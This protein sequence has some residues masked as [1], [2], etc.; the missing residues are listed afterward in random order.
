MK[1]ILINYIYSSVNM[2]KLKYKILE[3]DNDLE[4]LLEKKYYISPNF[5]GSST[6]LVFM[7]TSYDRLS[8]I[9]ER[10][11]LFYNIQQVNINEVNIIKIYLDLGYDIYNGTIF[12]GTFLIQPNRK[13][14]IITDCLLLNGKTMDQID[15]STKLNKIKQ[16]IED[17]Y[18]EN[19]DN[20]I[21]ITTNKLTELKDAEKLINVDIVKVNKTIPIRGIIFQPEFTGT[22][23]IFLFNNEM[24]NKQQIND[25]INC[26][27]FIK[28]NKPINAI[29]HMRRTT[30]YDVYNLYLDN[31][32]KYKKIDIAYIPT[33]ECSLLCR[34]ITEKENVI[35]NCEYINN[36]NL[37]KPIE[38]T[39]KQITKFKELNFEEEEIK[40]I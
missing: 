38:K 28:S 4:T 25:K 21:E 1:H 31:D 36:K 3:F 32:N 15:I 35:M 17:N 5:S 37:W 29:F 30:I 40:K 2:N 7:K 33:I 34:K 8:F 6:F 23:L 20:S 39:D 22:K 12:D 19:Y 27:Y 10:K 24:K 9:V 14:F 13:I 26:H 18:N 16:F 11:K